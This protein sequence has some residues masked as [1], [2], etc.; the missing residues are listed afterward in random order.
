MVCV[1]RHPRGGPA[2]GEVDC[3][4]PPRPPPSICSG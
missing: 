4:D 2:S 3:A 1:G